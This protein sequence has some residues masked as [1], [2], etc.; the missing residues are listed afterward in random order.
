MYRVI[1]LCCICVPGQTLKRRAADV[2]F[3]GLHS[4]G[5]FMI[6]TFRRYRNFTGF[7]RKVFHLA[8]LQLT[9]MRPTARYI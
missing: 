2:T 7:D 5:N 1:L 6:M 8:D 9:Y 3:T 4:S